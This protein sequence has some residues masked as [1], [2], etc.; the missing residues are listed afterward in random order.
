MTPE[1]AVHLTIR[2]LRE[3]ERDSAD[4]LVPRLI[5]AGID[6]DLANR[7]SVLVPLA[8]SRAHYASA[9]M[10]KEYAEEYIIYD[11]GTR[12]E[13]S[14]TLQSDPYF[15]AAVMAAA[16]TDDERVVLVIAR[17]SPEYDAINTTLTNLPD[18]AVPR[19][20]GTSSPYLVCGQPRPRPWWK[21]WGS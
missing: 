18:G 13:S 17:R 19:R 5:A 21:F 8:F 6:D 16:N 10:V 11:R 4:E 7:L 9:P 14:H 15:C 3:W 2:L 20:I 1:E 12:R